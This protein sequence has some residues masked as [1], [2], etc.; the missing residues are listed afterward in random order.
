METNQNDPP[1]KQNYYT[2]KKRKV[3]DFL[4]GFLPFVLLYCFFLFKL[5]AEVGIEYL[6]YI[7]L[8]SIFFDEIGYFIFAAGLIFLIGFIWFAKKKKRKFIIYGALIAFAFPY[9]IAL[10]SF[11]SCLA[12]VSSG[13]K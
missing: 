8:W 3:V 1:V 7:G 4:I 9:I 12:I 2:S 13:T 5:S 10:L 6:L 11:G